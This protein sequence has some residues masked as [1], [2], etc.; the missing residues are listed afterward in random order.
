MVVEFTGLTLEEMHHG[1]WA[2]H[3]A[4]S[5]GVA[6]ALSSLDGAATVEPERVVFGDIAGT[7]VRV[8][9][10]SC[11]YTLYSPCIHLHHNHIYTYVHLSS[12]VHPWY[13]YT[14]HHIHLT[15]L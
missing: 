7:K 12:T 3:Q 11:I 8:Y 1:N 6:R 2:I 5:R 15:R 4:F 13:M 14:H 9:L 10:P